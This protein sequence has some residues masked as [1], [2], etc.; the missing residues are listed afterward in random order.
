MPEMTMNVT[1]ACLLFT[2]TPTTSEPETIISV[3]SN[4][5]G[6]T[7]TSC[8]LS[9][10]P[11]QAIQGARS[12]KNGQLLLN[13][14]PVWLWTVEDVPPRNVVTSI[15]LH[16]GGRRLAF[17]STLLEGLVDL[18]VVKQP[19]LHH[20]SATLYMDRKRENWCLAMWFADGGASFSAT[21]SGTSQSRSI[22][23][24]IYRDGDK[25]VDKRTAQGSYVKA[26]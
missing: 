19:T 21:F 4:Y 11:F 5:W 12:V 16:V 6:D 24:E 7:A 2:A 18:H 9:V 13:G 17:P 23:R 14:R 25:L 26:E 15:R 20:V 22:V 3:V 1:L 8:S 10:V